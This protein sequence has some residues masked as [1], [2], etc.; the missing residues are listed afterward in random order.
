MNYKNLILNNFLNS[1]PYAFTS[2]GFFLINYLIAY[3][4]SGEVFGEF[5]LY[6]NTVIIL[7]VILRFGIEHS[8]NIFYANYSIDVFPLV[9]II[10]LLNNIVFVSLN[11]FY[12]SFDLYVVMGAFM[13]GLSE[14]ILKQSISLGIL[15]K[16]VV[17]KIFYTFLPIF[18]L[19]LIDKYFTLLP[20]THNLK[21]FLIIGLLIHNI[22]LY[23]SLNKNYI[24]LVNNFDLKIFKKL[25]RFSILAFIASFS[26]IIIQ[27]FDIFI[28]NHYL[29]D[30]QLVTIFV[31]LGQLGSSLSLFSNIFLPKFTQLYIKTIKKNKYKF[32]IKIIHMLNKKIIYSNLIISFFVIVLSIPYLYFINEN[33]FKYYNLIFF[34]IGGYFINSLT[35]SS[36]IVL[37]VSKEIKYQTYRYVFSA[38][39][40]VSLNIALV[41]IYGIYGSALSFLITYVSLFIFG[42]IFLNKY[43]NQLKNNG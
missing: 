35:L 37:T 22:Y 36:G 10:F 29:N 25:T 40:S 4:Y 5:A 1:I 39:I 15:R 23:L 8:I 43:I 17:T 34:F 30:L 21:T 19:I 16:Y 41:P 2:M 9:S 20:G 28:L 42:F 13:Y 31:L 12:F 27:K 7:S 26:S 11:Y 18:L 14:I 33:Y 32:S 38:I 6:L 24:N 3:L